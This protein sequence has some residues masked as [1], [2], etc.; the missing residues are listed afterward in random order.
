[1]PAERILV[2]ETY[3]EAAAAVLSG[4]AAAY[5]SVARAHSGFIEQGNDPPLEVVTVAAEKK[6]LAIGCFGFRKADIVFK[7]MIDEA[8]MLYIG[9]YEHRSMMKSF[10]FTDIEIDRVAN[11]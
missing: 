11:N 7:Q 10:G 9:S 4:Y 3:N 1:M 5:A 8:L 2:F 6:G